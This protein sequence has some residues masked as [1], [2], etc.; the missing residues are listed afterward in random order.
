MSEVTALAS[1]SDGESLCANA[2]PAS[3]S[4]PAVVSATAEVSCDDAM[5][6]PVL[7]GQG[8]Q[9]VV[10]TTVTVVKSL[11]LTEKISEQHIGSVAPVDVVVG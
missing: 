7:E 3:S 5:V 11:S 4:P 6:L 9:V 2:E 10:E 8:T 1:S